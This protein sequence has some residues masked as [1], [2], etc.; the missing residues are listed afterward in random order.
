MSAPLRRAKQDRVGAKIGHLVKEGKTPKQ[1]AG[2]AYAMERAG[3]LGP[4]GQ[5]KRV[6]KKKG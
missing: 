1:A 6:K 2:E 5:Y 4:G 3:R